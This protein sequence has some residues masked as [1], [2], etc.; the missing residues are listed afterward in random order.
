MGT[1]PHS[2]VSGDIPKCIF[3]WRNKKK[4]TQIILFSRAIIKFNI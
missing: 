2:G 3:S 1:Q 4:S